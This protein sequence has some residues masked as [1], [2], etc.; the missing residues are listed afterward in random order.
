MV[1]M[2][3][4]VGNASYSGAH[5]AAKIASPPFLV[6]V[7]LLGAAALLVGPVA[8]WIDFKQTK[9]ALP[10]KAPLST[11]ALD[12]LGPYEVRRR[13]ILDPSVVDALGTTHYISWA[14]EDTS[15]SATD[16]LRTIRLLVTYYS[17]GSTLVP[18]TPDVC[19]RG[20]GYDAAQPHE[21]REITVSTLG[22]HDR[23]LPV[24][25]C[26][27]V[28][29]A[30]FN[31]EKTSVVYTFHSNGRFVAT[32]TGVRLLTHNPT[33]TYAYFSKVEVSFPPPATREET[34]QGAR[35]L[36]ERLLPML[37]RDHWPDFEDAERSAHNASTSGSRATG[38]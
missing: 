6:A 5:G 8:R 9:K 16:P 22:S 27:F 4:S 15:V 21:N 25:L 28:K 24:R 23:I 30:V 37:I 7:I 1:R 29:T 35:R 19:F 36:F 13:D 12:A 2:D 34:L 18:H 3:S 11:L 20:S 10:L 38:R 14:L 17:G 26:T 32:R 31:Q 33:D